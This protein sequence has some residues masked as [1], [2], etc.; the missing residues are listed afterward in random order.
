MRSIATGLALAIA[1]PALAQDIGPAL[2]M[3]PITGEAAMSHLEQAERRRAGQTADRTSPAG[4]AARARAHCAKLP[5]LRAKH[6][7]H[8]PR[9]GQLAVLCR[10][11]GF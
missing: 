2:E 10:Q 7:A 6:G 11:A 1:A 8:D 4:S 3:G 9:L 5:A